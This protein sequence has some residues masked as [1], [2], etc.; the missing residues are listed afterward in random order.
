MTKSEILATYAGLS[1][2]HDIGPSAWGQLTLLTMDFDP[3][4]NPLHAVIVVEEF[5]RRNPE[6]TL[7][8]SD[9]LTRIAVCRAVLAHELETS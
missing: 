5:K 4:K 2:M 6:V 9:P 7:D 8:E 1:R 3:F